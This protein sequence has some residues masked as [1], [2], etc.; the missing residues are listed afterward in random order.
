M[1]MEWGNDYIELCNHLSFFC[2]LLFLDSFFVGN[3][4]HDIS[5]CQYEEIK[6]LV[7]NVK[8]GGA[9]ILIGDV[10]PR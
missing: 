7:S 9:T 5:Q 2:K 4:T 6:K 1:I 10:R 8:S 3:H